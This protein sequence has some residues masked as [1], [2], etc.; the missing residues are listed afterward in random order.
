MRVN[1]LLQLGIA[2]AITRRHTAV[3]P[4]GVVNDKGPIINVPHG[5][6]HGWAV[7]ILPFIGQNNI[8]NKINMQESVYAASNMTVR[9][10]HVATFMSFRRQARSDRLRG[11]PPTMSRR[12][13]RSIITVSSI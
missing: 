11:V 3:L 9:D 2:W 7:Q 1:N 12:R 5:Y 6:H 8:Y 13:S 10:V 4:P